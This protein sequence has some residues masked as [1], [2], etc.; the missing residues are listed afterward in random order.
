MSTSA[1]LRTSTARSASGAGSRSAA[2]SRASTCR[3]T[4]PRHQPGCRTAGGGVATGRCQHQW[5]ARRSAMSK[6]AALVSAG[7]ESSGQGMPRRTQSSIVWTASA[8]SRPAGGI[9]RSP[10][11]RTTCT[12]RLS[13]GRPATATPAADRKSDRESKDRPPSG[14]PA[15]AEWHSA[16]CSASS[17]RTRDS[18]NSA[19]PGSAAKAAVGRAKATAAASNQPQARGIRG[20]S[21]ASA[22]RPRWTGG[23]RK[24]FISE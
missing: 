19:S 21:R 11:Y 10:S 1:T 20:R 16:Q 13:S 23:A 14:S 12:S 2:S 8:G 17:G 5:A 6:A 3:S 24:I 7:A 22:V 15:R 9:W 4:S 18:K